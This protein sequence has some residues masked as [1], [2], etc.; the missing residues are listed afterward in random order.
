MLRKYGPFWGAFLILL[1]VF[2]WTANKITPSF[3]SCIS[4]TSGDYGSKET[5]KKAKV[6]GIFVAS[7][8]ICTLRL[9]DQHSGFFA[10]VAA[11]IVAWFTFTLKQ[12]TTQLWRTE[13]R[14]FREAQRAFVFI[15]GFTP[16]ITTAVD[17]GTK[18]ED[19]LPRYRGL[20]HLYMH[21]FAVLPRWK[22][23]GS[24][25]TQ[26]MRIQV[27]FRSP[28]GPIPPQYVYSSDPE[29]FFLGP[30][31]IEHSPA[32]DM[33]W[34]QQI[35][36]YGVHRE[37]VEPTCWIWGRAEYEDIFGRP[38]FLEWCYVPRFDAHDGKR[39]RVTFI[40]WGDYNRSDGPTQTR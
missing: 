34:A 27:G 11:F 15:D 18:S 35:I 9:V 40:Q 13:E 39:L 12:S 2:F 7:E 23:G 22:N 5:D 3:Q 30:H 8:S 36:D 17:L 31:A 38:H 24:T 25:P 14:N 10:A 19:L 32:I 37:G 1:V 28:P 20:P 33:P 4:Q 16:E 21:R 26:K 29:P 6:I